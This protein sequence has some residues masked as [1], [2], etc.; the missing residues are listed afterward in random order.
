MLA[1]N[2]Q[3]INE[4]ES[5]KKAH[6]DDKKSSIEKVVREYRESRECFF[7][8]AAYGAGFYKLGFY[9]ARRW[10]EDIS[11]DE[12]PWIIFPP[13]LEDEDYPD[14]CKYDPQETI[15]VES[16]L[17]QL[18][19]DDLDNLSGPWEFYGPHG[20]RSKCPPRTKFSILFISSRHLFV[21]CPFASWY[22]Q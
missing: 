16:Y 14:W 20:V 12:F 10:L 9:A 18:V 21:E 3:Q 5:L 1:K 13:E 19:F 15:T 11:G 22:W 8:K 4:L 6:S 17:D 2:K 7:G